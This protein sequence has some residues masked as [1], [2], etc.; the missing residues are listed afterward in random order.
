MI[1]FSLYC[2]L[3]RCNCQATL[4]NVIFMLTI[5]Y[6]LNRLSI[7]MPYALMNFLFSGNCLLIGVI[8]V[9]VG[10]KENTFHVHECLKSYCSSVDAVELS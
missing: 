3:E 2:L 4:K 6:T 9:Y 7:I 10:V 1:A 5:V 8:E